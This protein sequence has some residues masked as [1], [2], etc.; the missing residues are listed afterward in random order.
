MYKLILVYSLLCFSN[1]FFAQENEVAIKLYKDAE[2]AFTG[3][4]YGM[5]ISNLDVAETMLKGTN[6]KIQS[7]KLKSYRQAAI[8]DSTNSFKA[9]SAYVAELQTKKS[10]LAANSVLEL[11][12]YSRDKALLLEDKLKALLT[13]IEGIT[14][15]Q[16]F[17]S[18]E[19]QKYNLIDFN[20]PKEEESVL[21]YSRKKNETELQTGLF[22]IV[23]DKSSNLIVKIVKVYAI[24]PAIPPPEETEEVGNSFKKIFLCD[25]KTISTVTQLEKVNKK[26]YNVVITRANIDTSTTYFL[27]SYVPTKY[28]PK[29]I[30]SKIN[31]RFKCEG[32][33][34][35]LTK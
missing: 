28:D 11:S 3:G 32:Y 20:K 18:V 21:R 31:L 19:K 25:P 4:Q 13:P 24:Y 23:V 35:K 29:D 17:S 7:L 16:S 6:P 10:E 15:G 12:N 2:L 33:E 30:S 1:L 5:A 14:I 8:I 9:Y 22:E 34:R 26:E 27:K